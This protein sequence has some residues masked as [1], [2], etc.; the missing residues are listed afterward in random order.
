M[1]AGADTVVADLAEISVRPAGTALSGIADAAQAYSQLRELVAGRRPAVFLAFDG[2]LSE[3]VAQPDAATP[4]DGA[5]DTLRTL[6]ALCPVAVISGRDLADVRARVGVDGLW[7]A[8]SHGFELAAPDGTRHENAEAAAARLAETLHDVPG[9]MLENKR[10]AVAAHY[11]NASP[12]DVDRVILAVRGRARSE[13]LRVSAGRKVIELRPAV[14]WD[15]GTTLK[16]F[17]DHIDGS[18]GSDGADGA[19]GADAVL[20]IC[21]G[22]DITDEDALDAVRFDGVG[23]VVHHDEDG[24]R[25]SGALLLQDAAAEPD[26]PWELV[27][28]GYDA[29]SERLREALC[30]VGNGYV[31]TRGCAPEAAASESHSRAR[32]PPASTTSRPT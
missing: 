6:S 19:D 20:P 25:P 27:Y 24:D 11:R 17:L 8:G 12:D 28:E 26:A 32:T 29:G 18:D 14:D 31:A 9:I 23:I 2:T 30:T 15:R 10:F 4:V 7:Y 1:S 5:A 22:D 16:W 21:I 3:I 13:G